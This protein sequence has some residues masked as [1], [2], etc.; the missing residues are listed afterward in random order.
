MDWQGEKIG[1]E[2]DF[3][4][5]AMSWRQAFKRVYERYCWL[6]SFA[7]IN[8]IA[9]DTA[10]KEA[11]NMLMKEG[12]NSKYYTKICSMLEALPLYNRKQSSKKVKALVEDFAKTFTGKDFHQAIKEL[13]A[14]RAKIRT[15]DLF[16]IAVMLGVTV[17]LAFMQILFFHIPHQEEPSHHYKHLLILWPVYRFLQIICL[18]FLF[19]AL[20]IKQ[21]RDYKVNY[22]YIFGIDQ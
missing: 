6:K 8:T 1:Q 21:F 14:S 10:L 2:A 5:K 13:N 15:R 9:I 19:T 4:E 16:P 17:T 7:R 20:V 3:F 22:V 12:E 11:V 18:C